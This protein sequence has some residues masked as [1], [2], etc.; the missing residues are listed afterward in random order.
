V[1]KLLRD[2]LKATAAAQFHEASAFCA[3]RGTRR[4]ALHR[5]RMQQQRAAR[6]ERMLRRRGVDPYEALRNGKIK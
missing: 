4:A 3:P 6:L 5:A 1:E 2:W